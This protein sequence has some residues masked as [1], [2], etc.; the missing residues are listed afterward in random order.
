MI[1]L[2]LASIPFSSWIGAEWLT[3]G[4]RADVAAM[5]RRAAPMRL[6]RAGEARTRRN[7]AQWVAAPHAVQQVDRLGSALD[8]ADRLVSVERA[9]DGMLAVDVL[10]AD[11]A[12]LRTRLRAVP[13]IPPLRT[14]AERRGD[15]ALIVRFRSR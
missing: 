10:T 6:A 14:V 3:R 7:L 12:R 9:A 15:G 13:G 1:A 4:A 11:P 5:A 2:L 8:D